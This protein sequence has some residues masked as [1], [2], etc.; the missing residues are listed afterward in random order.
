[1][2]YY[3]LRI[4]L[5]GGKLIA[6]YDLILISMAV[7]LKKIYSHKNHFV[8]EETGG[9]PEVTG[10]PKLVGCLNLEKIGI[11]VVNTMPWGNFQNKNLRIIQLTYLNRYQ[12]SERT[13]LRLHFI[14]YK[15]ALTNFI[16]DV[17]SLANHHS[18]FLG[19][20]INYFRRFRRHVKYL[21]S[22]IKLK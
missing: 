16:S 2:P 13:S 18:V 21:S 9:S 3:S 22:D 15:M 20:F 5:W 12:K 14:H 4:N 7:S 10:K 19:R 1:M 11:Y 17:S 6:F 8:S